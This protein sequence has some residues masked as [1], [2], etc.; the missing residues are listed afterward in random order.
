MGEEGC[1]PSPAVLALNEDAATAPRPP[2]NFQLEAG[3]FNKKF[4]EMVK[5]TALGKFRFGT[6]E[7][8]RWAVVYGRVVARKG[9]DGKK[10]PA[11]L[12]FRGS[13]VVLFLTAD[14]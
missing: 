1:G 8:D 14:R 6:P 10:A 2:A 4:A 3:A 7:Y 12:V 9:D 5:H 13:G 11:E